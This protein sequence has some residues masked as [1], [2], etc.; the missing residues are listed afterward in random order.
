MKILRCKKQLCKVS[1]IFALSAFLIIGGGYIY[2]LSLTPQYSGEIKLA[3]LKSQ[4]EVFFDDFGIPHIFA[5]NEEDAYFALG[6]AQAQ[7]RLFQMELI[8]RIASGRLA[9]FAGEE[10]LQ[11]DMFFRTLGLTQ[12]A[13]ASAREYM[14]G[15]G[16][17][18][19]KAARAYLAGINQFLKIGKTPIEFTILGIPKTPF[20][21][22]D[23]Y[24]VSAFTAFGFTWA[25]RT[26][27]TVE[28][29][30]QQFGPE[31]LKDL[32][33]DWTPG[34]QK[35]PVYKPEESRIAA[36]M[37]SAAGKIMDELP[38][39]VWLG[40]NSWVIGPQHTK[41]G[42]V[43]L[44]N[45]THMLYSQPSPWY[46]AFIEYPGFSHYGFYLAGFPFAMTGN[47]RYCAIGMTMFPGDDMD[48]YR[49]TVNPGNPNQVLEKGRWEDM[50]IRE[51]TIRIKG[52]PDTT[53]RVRS[54][55]RG[56]IVSDVFTAISDIETQPVSQWWTM[57][58]ML[59]RGVQA[60][61]LL[62]HANS[63][64]EAR[65]AAS[66]IHAPGINIMYGD[67]DNNI[68][69]WAVSRLVKRPPQ[70][71]SKMI[72]ENVD[73]T[74]EPLG[75]FEFSEN[76]GAENPPQGFVFSANNQ[77]DSIA[78]ILYPGYYAPD[79]R[80]GRIVEYLTSGKKWTV[81]DVK[82]MQHDVVSPV[83][84][85]VAK[86]FMQ[87]IEKHNV[88]KTS[89][90]HETAAQLLKTW[91]GD[92]QLD[93]IAPTIFYRLLYQVLIN[94]MGD[95]LGE[96]RF[97]TYLFTH[98]I[99]KTIPVMMKNDASPWWDN[100]NTE[101]SVESRQSIFTEC[102]DHTIRDLQSELGNDLKN[103][104][105]GK[106]H[107]LE[108]PHMLGKK[109][110]L[111]KIFNVGNYPV[112]GGDETINPATFMLTEDC[113]FPVA[114]GP[115]MRMIIDFS[116]LDNSVSVN[117]TGQS[118]YFMSEHYGDQAE[119]FNNGQYHRRMITRETIVA[120]NKNKLIFLPEMNTDDID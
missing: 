45:D 42:K 110:P 85:E 114:A 96:E 84:A 76:P 37:A 117:A 33:L 69:W 98:L 106:V 28:Y 115:S 17:P 109:K 86:T 82:T 30:A 55:P 4:V 58:K 35:I 25:F 19:Q 54:T 61:Y 23:I 14:N 60:S 68:A 29:I 94:S 74:N 75:F 21:E 44:A 16:E 112:I 11:T 63:I 78:G 13:E 103:W 27:P 39:P 116:D 89:S 32:Q 18:Y 7:E 2:L 51:E 111:N 46:E 67:R 64:D 83:Y 88:T 20:T 59:N 118:G 70:I 93:D 38:V 47:N 36:D 73:G 15:N 102:F 48:F 26:D 99:K 12:Y 43:I 57:R 79:N 104:Y 87:T 66:M 52:K 56:P 41:S 1:I 49:E 22:K 101:N 62:N 50:Q 100:I 24:L 9:E 92:H 91:D 108:H 5:E 113:V 107:K 8:R 95:E 34:T 65:Q 119:L 81:E 97:S 53:I 105:W 90:I 31:Y 71:N 120:Q 40:S 6:Y 77:P 10:A 72:L 80:A 3:G